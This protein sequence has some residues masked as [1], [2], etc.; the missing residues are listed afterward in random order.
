VAGLVILEA[1][2]QASEQTKHFDLRYVVYAGEHMDAITT[3]S[4][5]AISLNGYLFDDPLTLRRDKPEAEPV[6][7]PEGWEAPAQ[8]PRCA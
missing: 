5:S 7:P 2:I 3:A 6:P 4:G 1:T 8:L